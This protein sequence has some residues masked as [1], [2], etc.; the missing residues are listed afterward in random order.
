MHA[1]NTWSSDT[2]QNV[3]GGSGTETVGSATKFNGQKTRKVSKV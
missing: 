3:H 1:G 2:A